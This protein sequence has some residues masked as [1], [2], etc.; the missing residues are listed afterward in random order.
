M[1]TYIKKCLILPIFSILLLLAF[2]TCAYG[3]ELFIEDNTLHDIKI[4]IKNERSCVVASLFIRNNDG[5]RVY[6]RTFLITLQNPLTLP[7]GIG[8][9]LQWTGD[10][11]IVTTA[12]PVDGYTM[13]A[14]TNI[15]TNQANNPERI[16]NPEEL[17]LAMFC[18]DHA[19][20]RMMRV[21]VIT[22]V[23]YELFEHLL[24]DFVG[25]G[26]RPSIRIDV[27]NI[28]PDGTPITLR[29]ITDFFAPPQ[30]HGATLRIQPSH[31]ND[32]DLTGNYPYIM[33][34]VERRNLSV[35]P[36]YVTANIYCR[37][38]EQ[39]E[40]PLELLGRFILAPGEILPSFHGLYVHIIPTGYENPGNLRLRGILPPDPII[41]NFD[42]PVNRSEI[43]N[44]IR[45]MHEII[46]QHGENWR[47]YRRV[48]A[49]LERIRPQFF[50]EA[51]PPPPE[52]IAPQQNAGA[53][54][55]E[56][57]TTAHI[58][59]TTGRIWGWVAWGLSSILP[60][61]PDS[62]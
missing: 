17:R 41:A 11:A 51:F 3:N 59:T 13:P 14:V 6:L 7:F 60:D 56:I 25:L 61:N 23:N 8:A 45:T 21:D 27:D 32:W 58:T 35:I 49:T 22:N 54:E 33:P 50:Q 9:H 30:N 15:T 57:N 48:L 37:N 31:D 44:G 52:N 55:A 47:M 10:I 29:P 34:A 28:T 16:S 18:R 1:Y 12:I 38:P 4:A 26:F 53:A 46:T 42:P 40:V 19:I 39:P 36:P 2:I 20:R 62:F 43:L 5:S 24:R